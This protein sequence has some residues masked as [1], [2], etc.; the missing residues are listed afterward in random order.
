[1][2]L[3]GFAKWEKIRKKREFS[4]VVSHGERLHSP[5]FVIYV[6]P[7]QH[8]RLGITVSHHVGNAVQRNRVKRLL[9]EFFRLNKQKLPYCDMLI[10]A[11]EGA[12]LLKY[13]Q[14]YEE[15]SGVLF[16]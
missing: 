7:N 8:R 3:F 4:E 16:K 12:P 15:L 10:V 2:K 1:M 13:Q 6:R 9:R 5:H 14:V 11:K